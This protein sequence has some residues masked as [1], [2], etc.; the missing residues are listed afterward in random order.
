MEVLCLSLVTVLSLL[1]KKCHGFVTPNGIKQEVRNLHLP[2]T[3][4]VQQPLGHSL[5]PSPKFRLRAEVSEEDDEERVENPYQDP[6]YPELE[7]VNYA[8]PEYKV[9]QGVCSPA[10]DSALSTYF[11]HQAEQACTS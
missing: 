9:D 1:D 2:I 3:T 8:D 4:V 10:A 7:F 5:P 11:Q 6:N